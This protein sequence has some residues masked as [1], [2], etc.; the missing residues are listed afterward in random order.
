M[1]LKYH[2]GDGQ[3]W[4]GCK[5]YVPVEPT[6]Q[7]VCLSIHLIW[8]SWVEFTWLA[9][10]IPLPVLLFA[11]Q[12]ILSFGP[13]ILS[14]GSFSPFNIC[15]F[16]LTHLIYPLLSMRLN[17]LSIH[18][19]I[20]CLIRWVSIK[21]SCL[22]LSARGEGLSASPLSIIGYFSWTVDPIRLICFTLK[23]CQL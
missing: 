17:S 8:S 12:S 3:V 23:V 18:L 22:S 10:P 4:W 21:F 6:H 1:A 9:C 16:V 20:C 15:I 7:I 19:S 11:S 5:R 14:F 2:C 13:S